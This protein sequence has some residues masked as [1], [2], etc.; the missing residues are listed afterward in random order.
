[1]VGSTAL[2]ERLD[3]ED[4][5]ERVGDVVATVVL[6]VE[7]N[8]GEVK[9]LAGDGVLALFRRPSDA[10]RAAVAVV[11]AVA[12]RRSDNAAGG[13]APLD[14]RVGADLGP[15]RS[16][17]VRGS[18]ATR[19]V[20]AA[21]T[22]AVRLEGRAEPGTALVSEALAA[23]ASASGL[24]AVPTDR[25]EGAVVLRAVEGVVAPGPLP[26]RDQRGGH[27]LGVREERRTI[28]ALF[29][30]LDGDV[31]DEVVAN[32]LALGVEVVERF[33]GVVKDLAGDVVVALFG[34][35]FAHDDD[36]E[37]AVLAGL[38][39][40]AEAPAALGVRVGVATGRVVVGAVGAGRRIEYGAV[41]DAMNTAARLEAAAGTGE[42]LVAE[43]ARTD[44][45]D[46]FEWGD[47]RAVAAKGKRAPVPAR[48]ARRH[49]GG[50]A[51]SVRADVD[52]VGRS[53]DLRALIA[54]VSAPSGP[55][56]LTG[57]AG[58]GK[59]AL[60]EHASAAMEGRWVVVRCP[61]WEQ[62]R[63]LAAAARVLEVLGASDDGATAI[64]VE[65]TQATLEE[66]MAERLAGALRGADPPIRVLVLDDADRAD[67]GSVRA[68]HDAVDRVA[69]VSLLLTGRGDVV[70]GD[71][72]RLHLDPLS[73]PD[74][75]ALLEGLVGRAVL[76]WD[77]ERKVLDATRG[78][79]LLLRSQV[80]S[81]EAVGALERV[82]GRLRFVAGRT[83]FVPATVERL[84]LGRIDRL[85]A[86]SRQVLDAL[87]VLGTPATAEVVASVAS[88]PPVEVVGGLRTLL[89]LELALE[90]DGGRFE[91]A[92]QLV[93]ETAYDA[94][95]QRERRL[96][97][98]RA[99]DAI[100]TADVALGARHRWA[101]DQPSDAARLAVA[102]ATDA[103]ERLSHREAA[104]LFDLA[105]T[106]AAASGASA[107]RIG[108]L[109]LAA[110]ECALAAAALDEAMDALVAAFERATEADDPATRAAAAIAYEDA[111]F[112]SRR[113]RA[114][115]SRRGPEM[116]AGA[117]D[118]RDRL[119]GPTLGRLLAASARAAHFAGD[120][121]TAARMGT[122]AVD[123]ARSAGDAAALAY[124]LT[125]W[126]V[127]HEAPDQLGARSAVDA[128]LIAA[129]DAAGDRRLVFESRRLVLLD[130]LEGGELASAWHQ[131]DALGT[132]AAELGERRLAWL[133]P[134][135][136]GMRLLAEGELE[137]AV[138]VVA[139]L[140]E[141]GRRAAYQDALAV[142]ALQEYLLFRELG[143]AAEVAPTF[144]RTAVAAGA[145]WASFSASLA[146]ELGDSRQARA[147]LDTVLAD[148]ILLGG[149]RVLPT[150]IA[151]LTDAVVL[152][153]D[154]NAASHL[155]DRLAP[156]Q[157][158]LIVVGT[159]AA[160]LGPVDEVR[161]R[162]ARVAGLVEVASAAA[163]AAV[164]MARRAATPILLGWSLVA[165]AEAAEPGRRRE[166]LT[167]AASIA[168]RSG[169]RRLSARAAELGHEMEDPR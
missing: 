63:H 70:V 56:V 97:H 133:A 8:G 84:V 134:M 140:Y 23:T 141:L 136:H 2:G 149:D 87:A 38:A 33:G 153:D 152:L 101:A 125:A 27:A 50:G 139:A 34:A 104:S 64:D 5:A 52:L 81:L 32:A 148:E 142:H 116:L 130:E 68:V 22:G 51:A 162:L 18:G 55:V 58:V 62:E 85:D 9:D 90:A 122:E 29:A 138:P 103:R 24:V 158:H 105:A 26:P 67:A 79:P 135:W 100:D 168:A 45:V 112:E 96:L 53:G 39:I 40:V 20:G 126:R 74:A 37:R 147:A 167:E 109:W 155:L 47:E 156:W 132:L 137:A 57:E 16:V 107:G 14:V 160:V 150:A 83:P 159:G 117:H 157:G 48:V 127:A 129:A 78:N 82:E 12:A 1:V 17:P 41:G 71:L 93:R 44:I 92:H 145:R 114:D 121:G 28:V 131:I 31:E 119:D 77:T 66:A 120:I 61:S 95:L 123:V 75:L 80:A 99:A 118:D 161:S 169:S 146:A 144:E 113:P 46:R 59:S 102:A 43:A 73:E 164:A 115:A 65:P 25:V 124:A 89:D 54:A 36:A 86:P 21:I 163:T 3:P 69:D 49:L 4:V 88:I 72:H 166:L 165:A 110:G 35:P 30:A 98:R 11:E 60:V 10:L 13:S 94:L 151:M 76:P 15:V 111:M 128:E 42:V 143:R 7:A 91:L 106:A 108:T 19:S 154:G 6:A